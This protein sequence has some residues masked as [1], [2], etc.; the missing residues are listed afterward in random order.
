MF[1]FFITRY[2]LELGLEQMDAR[3]MP[4]LLCFMKKLLLPFNNQQFA[5]VTDNFLL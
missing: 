1:E 2:W 5:I 4:D 3:K